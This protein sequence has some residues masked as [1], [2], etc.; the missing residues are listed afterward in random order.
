[1][2]ATAHPASTP[3]GDPIT[4]ARKWR[5]ITL[6]TLLL[7]PAYWSVMYG[8]LTFAADETDRPSGASGAAA[9][10]FGLAVIPFVYIVLAFMS[11]HPRAPMAVVKAMTMT[12]VVGAPVS[13]LAVDA[14]TGL[15]AGIGA[16][17]ICALRT[18]DLESTRSRI[19]GVATV[20]FYVFVLVR[21]VAPAAVLAAPILP[22]TV[23]GLIDHLAQRRALADAT[24]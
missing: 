4:P 10:A 8:V 1:M 22:F 21:L 20:A 19:Y 18:D 12:I 14:V 24:V 17:G 13:A 16:G 23:I 2:T 7:V 3:V 6:A 5:A 9:L 11:L 15:V